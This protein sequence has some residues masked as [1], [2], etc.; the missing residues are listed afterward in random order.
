M[1]KQRRMWRQLSLLHSIWAEVMGA[2]KAVAATIA[3]II[4][5]D[6]T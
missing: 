4:L 3:A 2:E 5:A 1:Q 6:V